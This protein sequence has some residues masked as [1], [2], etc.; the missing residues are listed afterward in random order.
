MSELSKNYE[1]YTHV[2]LIK[3][4]EEEYVKCIKTGC[5]SFDIPLPSCGESKKY[6][7]ILKTHAIVKD[8]N[9]QCKF[10]PE[11][12]SDRFMDFPYDRIEFS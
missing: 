9:I 7:E 2:Y 3:R 4:F 5:K 12:L 8:K 1:C 6:Y 10:I 11:D